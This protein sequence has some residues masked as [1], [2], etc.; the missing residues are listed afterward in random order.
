MFIVLEGIDGSGTTTQAQAI[1]S[2]LRARGL[3]VVETRQPTNSPIGKHLR[4]SLRAESEAVS[5]RFALA[6][7]FAA[8]RLDHVARE[9][10]PALER[11]A[12]IVC[13][14]YVL[15][16]LVYQSLDCPL[17]W[18]AAINAKARRAD[19][20]VLLDLPAKT[21]IKRVE[22]RQ[23]EGEK[24]SEIFDHLP[25]QT[26]LAKRYRD[27]I[28]AESEFVDLIGP[29]VRVRADRSITLVTQSI[30]AAIDG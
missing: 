25:I 22:S 16:S 26:K 18:V 14:R 23:S 17:N 4:A 9:I 10:T 29:T 20:T 5:D 12:W 24:E 3:D 15:S 13:D 30:L 28:D 6:L 27:L 1:S 2:T 21:A 8:D 7:L 11:G 19:L